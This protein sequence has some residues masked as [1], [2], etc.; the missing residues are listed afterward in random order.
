MSVFSGESGADDSINA[1]LRTIE[2]LI[3]KTN[4]E[5]E[6]YKSSVNADPRFTDS[7]KEE[8]LSAADSLISLVSQYYDKLV[9]PVTLANLAGDRAEV[10]ALAAQYAAI[11]DELFAGIDGLTAKAETLVDTLNT[12][13]TQAAESSIL[14]LIGL[15]LAIVVVCVLLAVLIT[16]V[17][18]KPIKGLVSLVSDVSAGNLNINMNRS[19]VT[20]DEI[21]ELT[22]DIYGLVDVIKGITGDLSRLTRGVMA[23]GDID[24]RIEDG[25]YSGSYR[26]MIAEVNR[27]V[28]EYIDD[29]QQLLDLIEQV[30]DGNFNTPR[31]EITPGKSTR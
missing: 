3:G 30:G 6:S 16:R 10:V 17:I 31:S 5:L 27:F 4:A 22:M 20:K 8:R 7:Q 2:E 24:M 23:E 9:L 15:S 25:K 21:G 19:G 29:I 18:T 14:L 13:T 1:Q 28:D 26:E 12:E 11:S